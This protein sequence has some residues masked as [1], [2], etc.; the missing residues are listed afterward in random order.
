MNEILE[1]LI[2]GELWIAFVVMFSA[3]LFPIIKK[4]YKNNPRQ[5]SLPFWYFG[6]ISVFV[7]V[8]FFDYLS[9]KYTWFSI[10]ATTVLF[11]YIY[12]LK[13]SI[14]FSYEGKFLR[15]YKKKLINNN[16]DD[17]KRFYTRNRK[18]F[19]TQIGK[20]E[21]GIICLNYF[22]D[23]GYFPLCF[24]IM[25]DVQNLKL[26][27]DEKR[28]FYL[29]QFNLF[30]Q[31]QSLRLWE[32][33][34]ESLK[35][36]FSNDDI[37]Y[38]DSIIAFYKLDFNTAEKYAYQLLSSTDNELYKQVAEN[39]I[40]VIAENTSQKIDWS[41]YSYKSFA[42][43][44]TIVSNIE[45]ATQNLIHNLQFNGKSEEAEILF[46]KYVK[47]IKTRAI[48]QRVRILNLKLEYYRQKNDTRN[49]KEVIASLFDEY[50]NTGSLKKYPLL[51]SLLRISFNNKILFDEILVEVETCIDDV[52]KSDFSIVRLITNE[53]LGIHRSTYGTNNQSRIDNLL[54]KCK[55]R[56]KTIDIDSEIYKLREEDVITKRS[57][58]KFKS[59]IS[60]IDLLNPDFKQYEK[61]LHEKF[62]ILDELIIFDEKQ[63]NT[64][65][66]LDSMFLK[67]DE[68][69][70]SL[71]VMIRYFKIPPF[72]MSF[73]ILHNESRSLITRIKDIM[74][75]AENSIML[76]DYH[77]RLSHY[78]CFLNDKIN[79]YKHFVK[80]KEKN[81]NI[82]HYANWIQD[83]YQRLERYF[84]TNTTNLNS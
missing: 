71:D 37:L 17:Y 42:T 61:Q 78:Y 53:V 4:D 63:N 44:Q 79:G 56:I 40:A 45:T 11:I 7:I 83:W 36:L 66:L 58:I 43:S 14:I 47:S 65:N 52:L 69:I 28:R 35:D 73:Q 84:S 22:T 33:K 72:S 20:Y 41:N 12:L 81:I 62:A 5:K 38:I 55:S 75:N 50:R 60:M 26:T 31:T 74:Q 39:N 32:S 23:I 27:K 9:L 25:D 2:N 67:L 57:Y 10:I 82:Q 51:I 1:Y 24:E 70:N 19:I 13:K 21:Y 64:F 46:N 68:M 59:E 15:T 77:L 76:A 30:C 18:L 6:I 48:D 8:N 54:N 29:L 49:L 3:L 80:F 34:Y 16:I